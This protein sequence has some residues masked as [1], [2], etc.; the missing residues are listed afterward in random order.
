MSALSLTVPLYP[1]QRRDVIPLR[2]INHSTPLAKLSDKLLEANVRTLYG[3][4]PAALTDL[5][6]KK[7]F[8][9]T[10]CSQHMVFSGLIW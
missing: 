1:R 7:N 3:D 8:C 5:T 6:G 4:I 2:G 10:L 9:R